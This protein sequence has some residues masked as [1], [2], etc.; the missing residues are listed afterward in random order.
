[1]SGGWDS[2]TVF[3]EA[4]DNNIYID[5][6]HSWLWLDEYNPGNQEII[7][8]V[9]PLLDLFRDKYGRYFSFVT[10]WDMGARYWEDEWTIFTCSSPHPIPQHMCQQVKPGYDSAKILGLT[11]EQM[12][13][14]LPTQNS[15]AI[16]FSDKPGFITEFYSNTVLCW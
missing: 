5:L 16:K 6:L 3:M 10:D 4:M 8:N 2:H 1:M 13:N 9:Y 15:V 7:A 12:G 11:D 14:I